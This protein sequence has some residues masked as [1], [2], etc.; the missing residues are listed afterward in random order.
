[1]TEVKEQQHE[2]LW[3]LT[4]ATAVGK[5]AL[6][7]ALAEHGDLEIVSM[8]SMLVYRGMDVGTAKP[9]LEER[10]GVAHHGMD[11]VDPAEGY[12]VTRWLRDAEVALDD[13]R[14]RGKQ[15]LF[16][17]GTG[18][19]LQALVRG[20]FD[21]PP[22]D[23]VIRAAL[24]ERA[25]LEGSDALHRE[26][27]QLDPPSGGRIHPNDRKRV[28]RALE[29]LQG[30]GKPLSS[31]QAEWGWHGHTRPER[32]HRVLG[33]ALP[34]PSL[35]LR[36]RQRTTQMLDGGWPEEVT[37]ILADGG[38][39]PSSIQA[40]GYREIIHLVQGRANR[41]DTEA[42]I[43]LRTRQFARKQRTWFKRFPSTLWLEPELDG[44]TCSPTKKNLAER[45]LAH[46]YEA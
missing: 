6:A 39:G 20:I 41:P 4:G 36:I 37:A 35:D 14:S 8:D 9:T 7:L 38:F 25:G 31:W 13:I 23:P 26:L 11:L 12:D 18:F 16:V 28:V 32:P 34:S 1:M 19:Y 40:L 24:E 30:T 3:V 5:T 29:V 22:T 15:A 10:R 27:L 42:H 2:A 45:A 46:F 17:G 44:E 43:A 21:G 33:L